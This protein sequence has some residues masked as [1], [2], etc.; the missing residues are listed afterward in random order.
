MEPLLLLVGTAI[1]WSVYVQPV[2]ISGL[3]C[4]PY[5]VFFW[6]NHAVL[7]T[8][9]EVHRYHSAWF[10]VYLLSKVGK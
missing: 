2:D 8:E 5:R 7:V 1:V 6:R 4:V 9:E 3:D 10:A